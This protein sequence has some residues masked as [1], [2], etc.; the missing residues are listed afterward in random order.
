MALPRV[1]HSGLSMSVR[2]HASRALDFKSYCLASSAAPRRRACTAAVSLPSIRHTAPGAA[3]HI[4]QVAAFLISSRVRS[5][6]LFEPPVG[7]SRLIGH[8]IR[9]GKSWPAG[10]D[11]T[12]QREPRRGN[13]LLPRGRRY[14]RFQRARTT[15]DLGVRL[16]GPSSHLGRRTMDAHLVIGIA[17]YLLA[18]ALGRAY[19]VLPCHLIGSCIIRLCCAAFCHGAGL[20]DAALAVIDA[21]G[22]D[23]RPL[24]E[25]EAKRP[26]TAATLLRVM[27]R[28]WDD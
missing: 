9:P 13:A 16:S 17:E 5:P 27:R 19:A 1:L 14:P 25:S 4:G 11:V 28:R 10:H 24:L 26:G 6:S 8:G 12:G 18:Y 7:L 23:A 20:D 22:P 15:G 3:P 21:M 2:P